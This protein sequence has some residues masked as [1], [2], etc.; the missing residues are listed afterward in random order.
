MLDPGGVAI[1]GTGLAVYPAWI[2]HQA[3]CGGEL[4][5]PRRNRDDSIRSHI[6]EPVLSEHVAYGDLCVDAVDRE[7][8][9]SHRPGAAI[10]LLPVDFSNGPL[11]GSVDD[12]L[13]DSCCRVVEHAG[14]LGESDDEFADGCRREVLAAAPTNHLSPLLQERI[15]EG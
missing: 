8:Q 10:D 14:R 7:V 15:S 9:L 13:A 11:I 4:L 12:E 3:I 5:H 6:G 2:V 1:V